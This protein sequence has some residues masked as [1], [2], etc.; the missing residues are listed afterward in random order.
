MKTLVSRLSVACHH[1]SGKYSTW[2]K[3]TE[4]GR[5]FLGQPN[6]HLPAT[7]FTSPDGTF[8]GPS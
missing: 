5:S 1:R 6:P 7:D 4:I 8:Q 3:S 2:K